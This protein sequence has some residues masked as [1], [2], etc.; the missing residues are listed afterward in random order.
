MQSPLENELSQVGNS[1]NRV[2][3][4]RVE[5]SRE[6]PIRQE[7]S[8]LRVFLGRGKN[9]ADSAFRGKIMLR[10]SLGMSTDLTRL[11][12]HASV[13]VLERKKKQQKKIR[14]PL[15][16]QDLRSKR[17]RT[18]YTVKGITCINN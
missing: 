2:E 13:W 15:K 8:A 10:R 5:C 4:E 6:K 11:F 14:F 18:Q 7:I 16:Q 1:A 9:E 17:K 12:L 3:E